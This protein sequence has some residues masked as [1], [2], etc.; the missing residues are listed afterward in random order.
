[1]A[2]L[3]SCV[4]SLLRDPGRRARMGEEGRRRV[5]EFDIRDMVRRQE[6]LYNELAT[7]AGLGAASP[8]H[9][10]LKLS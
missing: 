9:A 3:A 8:G 5:G 4:A 2:G 10:F 7:R 6:D 1:V